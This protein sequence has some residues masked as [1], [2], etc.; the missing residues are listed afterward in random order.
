MMRATTPKS[1]LISIY[2][3]QLEQVHKAGKDVYALKPQ[4]EEWKQWHDA[5][6]P[7]IKKGE[8]EYPKE[9]VNLLH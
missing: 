6:K 7:L 9:L 3:K 8:T 5:I 2:S 1:E 4:G